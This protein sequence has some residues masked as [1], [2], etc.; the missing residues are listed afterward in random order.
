M[1][2]IVGLI[3]VDF[4]VIHQILIRYSAFIR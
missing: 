2:E 3:S 1:D 4:D